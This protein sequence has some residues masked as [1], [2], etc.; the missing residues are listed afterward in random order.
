VGDHLIISGLLWRLAWPIPL[1][2]LVGTGWMVW[3]AL[4]YTGS[5]L[6]ELGMG[7]GAIRALPLALVVLRW[8]GLLAVVG[9][10][11]RWGSRPGRRTVFQTASSAILDLAGSTAVS[12]PC[13]LR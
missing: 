6:R 5:R 3:E 4:G 2:A 7:R 9:V 13:P 12:M 11:L 10:A 8:R 1:L